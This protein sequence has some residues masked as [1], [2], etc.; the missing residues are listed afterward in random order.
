MEG[1]TPVILIAEDNF[2]VAEM[3]RDDLEDAG[4]RTVTAASADEAIGIVDKEVPKAAIVDL[5]LA[6]GMT[7]QGLA[8]AL[9]KRGISVIICT[10]YPEGLDR[11]DLSFCAAVLEK[12]VPSGELL[13]AVQDAV[14]RTPR[15][16]ATA[17]VPAPPGAGRRTDR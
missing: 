4:Y 16:A 7:G 5:G 14:A 17:S 6:D 2:V 15:P 9:A 3:V 12:P 13:K 10:G 1:D 8:H 11:G